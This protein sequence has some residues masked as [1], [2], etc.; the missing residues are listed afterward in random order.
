MQAIKTNVGFE[1]EK[2][3]SDDKI[4]IKG[5]PELLRYGLIYSQLRP[6]DNAYQGSFLRNCKN[7]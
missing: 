1:Y 4:Y 3:L 6:N 5:F 2:F 7:H